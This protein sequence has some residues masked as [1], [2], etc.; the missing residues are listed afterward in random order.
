[1]G[2]Y[3]LQIILKVLKYF[4]KIFLVMVWTNIIKLTHFRNEVGFVNPFSE[5][6]IALPNKGKGY[7]ILMQFL[8]ALINLY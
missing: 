4:S 2:I 5:E 8:T 1:M 3:F 7:L 6:K